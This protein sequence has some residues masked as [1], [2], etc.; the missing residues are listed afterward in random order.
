M[1][2]KVSNTDD[3]TLKIRKNQEF[4]SRNKQKYIKTSENESL[5][6]AALRKELIQSV[7]AFSTTIVV[8]ETGSG[9]STKLVQYL[10][11]HYANGND[12]KNN[13]AKCIV[14][15][16]PRRVAAV[17]IAERVANERGCNLGDEVGYCI[18]FD[19]RTSNKTRIKFVTDGV[20]L[21]ECIR[22]TIWFL[23]LYL[24]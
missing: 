8:G 21:R 5:P 6:I 15:T 13:N 11:D 4:S 9:K 23:S 18:R 7:K 16:Q 24:L 22:Y 19:D 20:L 3:K 10:T 2:R 17:T 14:C 1:K 12:A